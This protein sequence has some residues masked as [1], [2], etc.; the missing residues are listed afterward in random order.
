M[1]LLGEMT[2]LSG[3][4][5]MSKRLSHVDEF[6]LTHAIAYAAQSPWLRHQS[7][8]DNILFGYPYDDIRYNA[9]IEACALKPDLDVLEDGDETEIGARS[10]IWQ[11][12]FSHLTYSQQCHVIE[13]SACPEARKPGMI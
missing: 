7:I 3:K 1:A 2:T 4:I 12:L 8:K 5:I 9:V 13:V 11:F 10:A 6:G